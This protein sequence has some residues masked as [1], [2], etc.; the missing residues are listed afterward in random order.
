MVIMVPLGQRPTY[1]LKYRLIDP[2]D[3]LKSGQPPKNGQ[4]V[5]SLP[6]YIVHTF[7]P[8]KKRQPLN[9]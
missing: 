4:T 6:I 1:L 5:H 7:L 3:T 9:N 8:P 2:M